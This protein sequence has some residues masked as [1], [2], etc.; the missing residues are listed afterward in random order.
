[1]CCEA[2]TRPPICIHR[3]QARGLAPPNAM[4]V[5][6]IPPPLY[7]LPLQ[8]LLWYNYFQLHHFG[9][10]PGLFIK[11]R[12]RHPCGDSS[13]PPSGER[14]VH[15]R[16][17]H[18]ARGGPAQLGPGQHGPSATGSDLD[19]VAIATGVPPSDVSVVVDF[20]TGE[21]TFT[22]ARGF[23]GTTSFT[24]SGCPRSGGFV[25]CCLCALG[26]WCLKG[27]FLSQ[28]G[29]SWAGRTRKFGAVGSP[30]RKSRSRGKPGTCSVSNSCKHAV[31]ESRGGGLNTPQQAAGG[32]IQTSQT[33]RP[34]LPCR[35]PL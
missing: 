16:V 23:M 29:A 1:M 33:C 20:E 32:P 21:F 13:I 28:P 24:Y 34:L 10:I 5:T 27:C 30:N 7:P 19:V 17:Q 25:L 4:A 12:H 15:R 8:H 22:P 26:W 11:E 14:L 35:P 2:A 3:S 6:T 9:F 31:V 18:A